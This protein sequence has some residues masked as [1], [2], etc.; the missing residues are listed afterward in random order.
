M[1][2]KIVAVAG[3]SVVFAASSI[4]ALPILAQT[5]APA[6]S[7]DGATASRTRPQGQPGVFGT[8]SAINGTTLTITSKAMPQKDAKNSGDSGAAAEVTY[9]IDASKATFSNNGES[10]TISNI[11]VGDS[12]MVQGTISGTSVAAASINKGKP[13][14]LPDA[15]NGQAGNGTTTGQAPEETGKTVSEIKSQS[16][17]NAT[18]QARSEQ[19]ANSQNSDKNIEKKR[20]SK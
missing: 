4:P 14:N 19:Q 7:A 1:N 18:G 9:T 20:F 3:L 2:K 15:K 13:K 8:V 5:D 6:A 17:S 16:D 12:V 10:S 11:A